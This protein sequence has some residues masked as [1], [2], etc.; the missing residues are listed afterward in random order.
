MRVFCASNE[1]FP[2]SDH[3]YLWLYD[4]ILHDDLPV[5]FGSSFFLSSHKTV[6]LLIIRS[7]FCRDSAIQSTSQMMLR[8][9]V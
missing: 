6:N 8:P 5:I 7:S 1:L 2:Q 3:F 4:S 9:T